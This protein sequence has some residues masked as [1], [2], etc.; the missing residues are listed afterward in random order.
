MPDLPTEIA[1]VGALKDAARAHH[2]YESNAL[3]GVPD[4]LWAGFYA[5]FVIGRL[6]NFTTPTRL[7]YL[8]ESAPAAND[9]P[10]AATTFVLQAL[11]ESA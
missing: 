4:E 11:Y 2:D 9:W 7:A 5:A 6:G 1:L 8:L 3:H 10:R